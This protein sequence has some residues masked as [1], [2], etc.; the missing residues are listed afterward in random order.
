[1]IVN[2]KTKQLLIV[3]MKC[4]STSY[5]KLYASSKEWIDLSNDEKLDSIPLV[6]SSKIQEI[7]KLTKRNI[8]EYEKTLIIRDPV[9]WLVSGYRFLQ[10]M[11][12]PRTL[13]Y[14]NNLS[15]HLKKVHKDT[16][17]DLFFSDH[18]SVMPDKYYFEDCTVLKLEE[19][20][21][22]VNEN[23][24]PSR[25]MYPVLDNKSA[26]L[27]VKITKHYCQLF[28]YDIEKS[29]KYYNKEILK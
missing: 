20:N 19:Q 16:Q 10:L 7:F 6:G 13:W 28:S 1:M 25:I 14:P 27:I 21:L 5:R 11:Y 15:S 29:I 26:D 4:G 18:C 8:N 12:N 3:P 24:T 22:K 2:D 23:Q 17:I 9:Q